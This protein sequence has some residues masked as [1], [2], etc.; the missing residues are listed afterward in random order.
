MAI[1]EAVTSFT[2]EAGGEVLHVLKGDLADSGS[3][4]AVKHPHLFRP[5]RV[6]HPARDAEPRI[7][8]ATAEPGKKRG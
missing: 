3:A 5:A 2:A 8:R 4:V 1:L 6:A 7:E